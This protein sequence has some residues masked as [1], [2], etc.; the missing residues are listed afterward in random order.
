MS[1]ID[2]GVR[3][4][5][6]CGCLKTICCPEASSRNLTKV[7]GAIECEF[8]SPPNQGNGS[9]VSNEFEDSHRYYEVVAEQETPRIDHSQSDIDRALDCLD[10]RSG[11]DLYINECPTSIYERAMGIDKPHYESLQQVVVINVVS[12]DS[13]VAIG[14]KSTLITVNWW[15]TNCDPILGKIALNYLYNRKITW[16]RGLEMMYNLYGGLIDVSWLD[17]IK[18]VYEKGGDIAASAYI[19]TKNQKIGQSV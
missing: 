4:T 2:V 6:C 14:W 19:R 10:L 3:A 7:T 1:C 17:N 12:K 16:L 9:F 18:R 11:R 13:S 15:D 8:A 5:C